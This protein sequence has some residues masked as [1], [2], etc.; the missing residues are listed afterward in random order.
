MVGKRL[1]RWKVTKVVAALHLTGLIVLGASLGALSGR[2]GG[3]SLRRHAATGMAVGAV[4]SC[5]RIL[6][7]WKPCGEI[8]SKTNAIDFRDDFDGEAPRHAWLGRT[9]EETFDGYRVGQGRLS[10][11]IV[12]AVGGLLLLVKEHRIPSTEP[13][14]V[15][16]DRDFAECRSKRGIAAWGLV[17]VADPEGRGTVGSAPLGGVL[18]V[19]GAK[20]GS[21][22][23]VA[24]F[25]LRLG[26]RH[27]VAMDPRGSSMVGSFASFQVGPPPPH[28]QII[29]T[30]GLACVRRG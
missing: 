26:A 28:R 29:Q 18:V 15:G 14:D 7:G 30:Y 1:G 10:T 23:E 17:P 24:S 6:C 22:A 12:E 20:R 27:A 8:R 21:A 19:V 3:R 9:A 2:R 25:L 5:T 16:Y 11:D 13:G 4:L